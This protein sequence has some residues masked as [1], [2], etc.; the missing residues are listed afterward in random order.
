MTT[1]H[2]TAEHWRAYAAGRLG[3][4]GEAAVET[5]VTACTTCRDAARVLVP[6]PAPTWEAVHARIDH[7]RPASP[8]RLL[9]RL[10]AR[11]DDVVVLAAADDLRLPWSIAVGGA[12]TSVIVA[13]QAGAL[14]VFAFWLLAPLV[15]MLAVAAAF[16][17]TDPLRELSNTTP[18]SRLRLTL[19]RTLATLVVALP[20]VL[21]LGLVIPGLDEVV[22]RA[23]LPSLGLT[24]A[25]LVLV[26]WLPAWGAATATAAGWVLAISTVQSADRLDLLDQGGAQVLF[27]VLVLVLSAIVVATSHRPQSMGVSR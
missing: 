18:A 21:L 17:A 13:A 12:V 2:L 26:T 9:S 11:D 8:L 23:L 16:D 24:G 6:D 3:P 27:A 15:P 4:D 7:A 10:G 5:H 22:W 14:D 20:A 19:L 1:W 25:A